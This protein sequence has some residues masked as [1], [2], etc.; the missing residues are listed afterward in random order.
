[1][2]STGKKTYLSHQINLV[3]L[4][5]VDL[6]T[7]EEFDLYRQI[8][9]TINC[10]DEETAALKEDNKRDPT[11]KLDL[12]SN[13]KELQQKLAKH[14]VAHNGT[15]R[16]VRLSSV[17]DSSKCQRS[18]SGDVIYPEGISWNV[19]KPSRRIAEFSSDSSRAMGVPDGEVTFD[20]VI[21]KWK[22]LDVLE[23]IVTDGFIMPILHEDGTVE[24][25]IY[26]F[27]TASAGQLRTDKIQ[28]M[29]NDKWEDV[30]DRLLCGLSFESINDCGGI[31]ANKLLAYIALASSATD[32]WPEMDIDRCIV[33]DDFE[34]PVTGL[35]DYIN[36]DYTIKRE[37]RTTTISH[38]DGCGMMLPSVSRKNFMLRAP[39]IKGLICSFDFLKF[40]KVNDAPPIIK[41][42]YGKEHNLVEENIQII[43]TKSQFKLWK[44]YRSWDHYKQCFKE[45]NCVLNRTNFEEDDIPDT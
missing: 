12:L 9:T 4:S 24:R 15:P 20:K 34:A 40:C 26:R 45:N 39:W 38:T 30:Q 36:N 22:S 42:I 19:L 31:N 1:V 33:V 8:I 43:F 25:K 32:P 44:Y 21:V 16:A 29:S 28:A 10:I 7:D 41:D 14:I 37:E 2:T 23:Q 35:V 27:A 6:F 3:S 5:T 11:V 17:I 18:E 13:K